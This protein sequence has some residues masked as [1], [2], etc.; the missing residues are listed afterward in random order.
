VHSHAGDDWQTC[1][2]YVL[3]R[4]GVVP[5]R[6]GREPRHR[7]PH[8][9]VYDEIVGHGPGDHTE[10]ADDEEIL[11]KKRRVAS[12]WEQ[13]IEPRGT[14][15]ETYLRSRRLDLPDEIAGEVLRFHPQCP[16][17]DEASGEIVR[18]PAM[19]AAMRGV[20]S[21]KLTGMHRTALTADGRKIGRRMLGIAA[22]AAIKLDADDAVTMG[23]VIGEG[24][25]TAL[26]ARQMGFRPAWALGSVGAIAGFP[27]LPGIEALTIL[28]E[29]GDNGASER[30]IDQCGQRWHDAEREVIIVTPRV[31]GDLNDAL[32]E[33]S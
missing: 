4:L 18:I 32:R 26:A 14:I 12:L 25:E 27:V 7:T 5:E 28:A 11:A 23:L 21:D 33:T 16:W 24:I 22:S 30:A 10:T 8:S 19:L 20:H 13:G 9:K 2:D 31:G 3:S 6:T 29:T 17:R 1:R 15:V